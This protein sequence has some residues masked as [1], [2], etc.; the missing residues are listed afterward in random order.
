M[1]SLLKIYV[2]FIGLSVGIA[3]LIRTKNR[4]L[5]IEKCVRRIF[6]PRNVVKILFSYLG[7]VTTLW[8]LT[9]YSGY[10][11][12]A[13]SILTFFIIAIIAILIGV[14]YGFISML[15]SPYKNIGSIIAVFFRIFF[16]IVIIIFPFSFVI[17]LLGLIPFEKASFLFFPLQYTSMLLNKIP[18]VTMFVPLFTIDEFY[19][20][21]EEFTN[22]VLITPFYNEIIL[23][24][25]LYMS[26]WRLLA[27]VGLILLQIGWFVSFILIVL[28]ILLVLFSPFFMLSIYL[29][30][31]FNLA[32]KPVPIV[33][34]IMGCILFLLTI[35]EEFLKL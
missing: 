27:F 35:I 4:P 24:F 33:G 17:A 31:R 34:I 13:I 3:E 19:L 8:I 14:A 6:S 32:T 29:R 12:L 18:I 26:G 16:A 1:I 15:T 21:F 5:A 2:S 9:R 20:T 25:K 23:A 30:D 7:I 28:M 11:V 22:V 10:V